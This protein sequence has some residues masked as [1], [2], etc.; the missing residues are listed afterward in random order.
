VV[1]KKP[2]PVQGGWRDKQANAQKGVRLEGTMDLS[3]RVS[4]LNGLLDQGAID[5]DEYEKRTA[6]LHVCAEIIDLCSRGDTNGLTRILQENPNLD[7]NAVVQNEANL[8]HIT[9]QQLRNGKSNPKILEILIG[10]GIVVDRKYQ[11]LTPLLQICERA[12]FRNAA[13]C[14]RILTENGADAKAASTLKGKGVPFSCITGAVDSGATKEVIEILCSRGADP[15]ET[16]DPHGPIL[17]HCIIEN[18]PQQAIILLEFG[19]DPNSREL[20]TGAIPL[21]SA[22]GAGQVDVVKALLKR[23]ANKNIPIMKDQ[24]VNAK[25]LAEYMAKND[26]SHSFQE[27]ARLF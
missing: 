27:I 19:A 6:A 23:G 10:R 21:A 2:A 3:V 5:D 15:N 20:Q 18:M 4:H 11:G 16:L 22:I 9:T 12:N 13:E 1:E 25:E 7:L 17:N 8:L 26:N 14:V 24:K